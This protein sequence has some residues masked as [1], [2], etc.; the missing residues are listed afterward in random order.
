MNHLFS[1]YIGV[2]I[3]VYLDDIIVYSDTI[4]EHAQHCEIIFDI[5]QEQQLNLSEKKYQIL[6]KKLHIL[7][8]IVD[9]NSIKMNPSKADMIL[10][11]KIPTTY[12]LLSGFLSL[13]GYLMDN[14]NHVWVLMGILHTLTRVTVPWNW[15]ETHQAFEQVKKYIHH[16][17]EHHWVSLDYSKEASTINMVTDAS[18]IEIASIVNQGEDWKNAKVV[19]FFLAK[20]NSVQQNYSVYE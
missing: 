17:R 6:V 9:D 14:I 20:L 7:G 19:A 8:H 12:E 13:V 2:F 5:L 16:W 18:S 15:T 10:N 11:W 1:S 4:E 3:D